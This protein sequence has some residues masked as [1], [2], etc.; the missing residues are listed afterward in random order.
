MDLAQRN[1]LAL[2]A[3]NPY[4]VMALGSD[5]SLAISSGVVETERDDQRLSRNE[6]ASNPRQ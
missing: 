1:S 2:I 6:I 4:E 3:C 5:T